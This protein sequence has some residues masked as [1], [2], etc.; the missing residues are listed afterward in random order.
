MVA[1]NTIQPV[2]IFWQHRIVTEQA[3]VVFV[4]TKAL[5]LEYDGAVAR[6][7][8][9]EDCLKDVW[10]VPDVQ[11]YN[12]PTKEK[13][14]EVLQE[15]KARSEKFEEASGEKDIFLVTIANIGYNL[16]IAYKPHKEICQAR[17]HVPV[18]RGT[19]LSWYE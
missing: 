16:R 8:L 4:H 3:A 6:G 10:G 5:A 14:I 18:K 13:M 2:K 17:G 19:D 7:K 11:V 15:L 9:W 1:S 12:D